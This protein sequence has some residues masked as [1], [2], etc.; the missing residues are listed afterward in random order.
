MRDPRRTLIDLA[1]ARGARG[2]G[3]AAPIVRETASTDYVATNMN[4]VLRGIP[5]VVVG[6]VATRL[7]MPFRATLDLNL[8]VSR[9]ALA[10]A[11]SALQVAGARRKGTSSIG[12]S[13]WRL[14]D[15]SQLDLIALDAAWVEKA[16]AQ[17][18]YA[19][20]GLP[21]IALPWLVVM[22]LGSGRLQD[23]A[24]VSRML[25][26]A[27]TDVIARVRRAVRQYRSGDA[28]DLESMIALGR[29]ERA[30]RRRA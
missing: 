19:S 30:E 7:Y 9:D 5:F 24:D 4:R 15:G 13:S 26:L 8:L 23:L 12:G 28:E 6:G 10:E 27:K 20:N 14:R 29:L 18:V 17:P 16:L 1:K 25:G 21:V 2:I 22:K 3:C 11:E